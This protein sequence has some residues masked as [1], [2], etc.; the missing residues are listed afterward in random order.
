MRWV[1]FKMIAEIGRNC[2]SIFSKIKERFIYSVGCLFF[3]FLE[4]IFFLRG[5][6]L[7]GELLLL[8]S[9]A[10]ESSSKTV[11]FRVAAEVLFRFSAFERRNQSCPARVVRV[12]G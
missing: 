5:F 11:C 8:K 9:R 2:F 1:G 10:S 4:H 6:I 12:S 3:R 7:L